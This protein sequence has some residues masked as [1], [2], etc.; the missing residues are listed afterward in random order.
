MIPLD[1]IQ[2]GGGNDCWG[3][4][5]PEG[6]EYAIFGGQTGIG[7]VEVA[8][9]LTRD[10][11]PGL[12]C[13]W[14]DIKTYRNYAY[15][16][17]DC[18]SPGLRIW[19]LSFLPDSV[20]LANTFGT[21]RSHNLT[22]D[23]AMGY[24]YL[25]HSTATRFRVLDLAN[26]AFPVE[27]Q[28]VTTT[29]LH[30]V[31]ARND[32]VWAAE[33]SQHSF[34]IW[35][36]ADKDSAVLITRVTIPGNGYVHNIWPT[37]DG[38]YV[39]TTEETAFK[40]VKIWNT[41]NLASISMVSEYVAPSNL[42][43]NA[44]I[45][46]NYIYISH[47][48]S[49]VAVIDITYPECPVQVAL[50]D[51]YDASEG[52][53]FNGCWGVY[54]HSATGKIFAST[55]EGGLYIFSVNAITADFFGTPMIGEAPL[56]VDF[57]DISPGTPIDWDWDFG[58]GGSSSVQNPTHV[59]APGI[60]NVALDLTTTAGVGQKSKI[61]YVTALAETLKVA[62]TSALPNTS[63]VWEVWHENNVP[64]KEIKLPV[65][66]SGVP[67]YAALDS[68]STIGCR[69]AYFE[70]KQLVFDN[71]GIGQGAMLLKADNGGGSPPLP[72]GNG[73]IAKIHYRVKSNATAGQQVVLTMPTMGATQHSLKATTLTT[74]YSPVLSGAVTTVLGLCNCDCH[75]D[76]ICDGQPD[77][78]DVV[79]TINNAFR[80]IPPDTDASCPH[81]GRSDVDCSGAIDIIDV[82]A[83]I[84]VVFRGA[85]MTST[86]CDPCNP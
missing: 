5:S 17:A 74:Q 82:V 16:V 15:E 75:G 55:I 35:N 9:G 53:N 66:L 1:T 18:G 19:D 59:F 56:S 3:W 41:S 8:T 34:S 28:T 84:N 24:A 12:S 78:L 67:A 4:I 43:H 86:Y 33:G 58:D 45:E 64:I 30:D 50:F 27:H 6:D 52:P 47:Y 40:T 70:Q 69:T 38:R 77:V 81:I 7:F 39:A 68:I 26:P 79:E 36:M 63:L 32:T 80:G 51:N 83:T 14:R 72:P 42:A 85:N 71:R 2:F 37:G 10:W 25:V 29:D 65:A 57:T 22:I 73:P 44:H 21:L 20:H 46:G 61:S 31:F 49:G 11:E 13:V 60:W 54:P 23:T 48:E 76:P 62:D